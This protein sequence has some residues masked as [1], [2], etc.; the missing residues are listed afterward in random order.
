MNK[1]IFC[2]V[3]M[4][5]VLVGQS[6]SK[7]RVI[8]SLFIPTE[9]VTWDNLSEQAKD[10]V[11]VSGGALPTGKIP[12]DTIQA[13][14]VLLIG[15]D[16]VTTFFD[17][18]DSSNDLY[19]FGL[20]DG[21]DISYPDTILTPGT[22]KITNMFLGISGRTPTTRYRI[23]L[24]A[25]VYNESG[26]G[27]G[28]LILEKY[29]DIIGANRDSVIIRGPAQT[30]GNEGD[31]NV[32]ERCAE[33]EISNVTL[34]AYRVKYCVHYDNAADFGTLKLTNVKLRHLGGQDGYSYSLGLGL[35]SN[36]FVE[37]TN[38][39]DQ[40]GGWFIYIKAGENDEPKLSHFTAKGC[41]INNAVLFDYVGYKRNVFSFDGCTFRKIT[42]GSS[43]TNYIVN[44]GD[45]AYNRGFVS[46]SFWLQIT[47]SSVG[48]VDYTSAT[49]IV[50][51]D[52]L[53]YG[54]K[55]I[56]SGYNVKAIN[57]GSSSIELG[58]AVKLL[59]D[60]LVKNVY[61]FTD[62]PLTRVEKYDSSGIFY[63]FAEEAIA[64]L[65]TGA[66]QYSGLP[67]AKVDGSG[68]SIAYGDVLELNSSGVLIKRTTGAI[69]AYA[70]ETVTTD[71]TSQVR[72]KDYKY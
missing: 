33:A 32:I 25:G 19:D 69:I 41:I 53:L 65:G 17:N 1:V 5:S 29:V 28:G 24:K 58:H 15:S 60:T 26:P 20:S 72:L 2:F 37:M 13:N 42:P 12:A 18:L 10:S 48:W 68:T 59:A 46:P 44:S 43:L 57:K 31:A 61:P 7:L 35:R 11:R 34:E 56:I 62:L 49:G 63:G 55:L 66:I 9:S 39:I 45:S 70:L 8:D 50:Y 14:T 38:C 6:Y 51:L 67:L 47:N 52:S 3:L 40:S 21:S 64:V 4:A 30:S 16:D 71:T 22:D 27:G 23:F 54:S 36:Q